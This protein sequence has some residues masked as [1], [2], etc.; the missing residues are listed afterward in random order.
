MTQTAT[1][2]RKFTYGSV[3]DNGQTVAA[4]MVTYSPELSQILVYRTDD[5]TIAT[6]E[7]AAT[8]IAS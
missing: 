6:P 2:R 3:Q 5:P 8:W 4:V 7:Q 1:S